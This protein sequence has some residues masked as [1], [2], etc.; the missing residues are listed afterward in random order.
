MLSGKRIALK[1]KDLDALSS[2]QS[3]D[4]YHTKTFSGFCK[5]SGIWPV[6]IV[7]E[8]YVVILNKY[9]DPTVWTMRLRIYEGLTG[10]TSL[11]STWYWMLH[12]ITKI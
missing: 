8:G 5:A 10:L 11:K 3:H 12:K 4:G 2:N 9:R 7:L 1:M 6:Y